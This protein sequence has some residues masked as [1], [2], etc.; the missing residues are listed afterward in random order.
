MT[1][2]KGALTIS[3]VAMPKHLNTRGKIFGGWL[4]CQMD[5]AALTAAEI[6]SNG[7]ATTRAIKPIE[8][9]HPVNVG[10]SVSC[11]VS[12]TEKGRTS[13]ILNIE[14]WIN[15]LQKN[16]QKL[17]C[18]SIFIFVAID[19]NGNKRNIENINYEHPFS[20][21]EKCS[22]RP[23]T[24]NIHLP[25]EKESIKAS[26]MIDNNPL[27]LLSILL[28]FSTS[29]VTATISYLAISNLLEI[30]KEVALPFLVIS[31]TGI[32]FFG[33]SLFNTSK[34]SSEAQNQPLHLCH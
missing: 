16:K 32:G 25:L 13:M 24:A 21:P 34:V 2:P 11:Y 30:R 20:K 26:S 8:Y 3:T 27:Y 12:L 9:L 23:T 4:A 14:T 10:D 15:V 17:V 6:I 31:A 22:R 7:P 33:N 19:E 28:A 18:T 1:Q 29:I 5:L